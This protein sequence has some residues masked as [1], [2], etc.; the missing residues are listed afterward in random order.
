MKPSALG[1]SRMEDIVSPETT[2]N[3]AIARHP[4]TIAVFNAHGI[5]SCWGGEMTIADAA[6]AHGI[7][8]EALTNALRLAVAA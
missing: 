4:R 2:V 1:G 3:D 6:L 8:L 5:D 7:A